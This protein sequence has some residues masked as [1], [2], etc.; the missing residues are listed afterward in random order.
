MRGG[1]H[2]AL[3]KDGPKDR[4][5]DECVDYI[6]TLGQKG[7]YM[8][9]EGATIVPGTPLENID[10]MVEASKRASEIMNS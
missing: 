4:I 9:A 6:T 8:L 3:I 7:G 10:A 5:I 1:P 2:P